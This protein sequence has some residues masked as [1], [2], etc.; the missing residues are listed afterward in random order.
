MADE[1]FAK[2]LGEKWREQAINELI[3]EISPEAMQKL[4]EIKSKVD[5]GVELAEQDK[6]DLATAMQEI[7]M[8]EYEH[9]DKQH[10]KAFDEM[11]E[12]LNNPNPA[13]PGTMDTI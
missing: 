3:D 6:V 8:K 1:L 11:M 2:P 13:L 12:G 4:A 7:A 10:K 5:A 9:L